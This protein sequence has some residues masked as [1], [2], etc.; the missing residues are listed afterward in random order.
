M[1]DPGID[2][3]AALR[4]IGYVVEA[5][6]IA[7]FLVELPSLRRAAAHR[8]LMAAAL[9]EPVA[10]PEPAPEPVAH[11]RLVTASPHRP[12]LRPSV[13]PPRAPV[14][15][16]ARRSRPGASPRP[17]GVRASTRPRSP[18]AGHAHV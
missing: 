10:T 3:V 9:A 12:T 8:R 4:C 15:L 11:L 14:R 7:R 2:P 1:T 17:L 6:G 16:P 13:A 18:L 5:A